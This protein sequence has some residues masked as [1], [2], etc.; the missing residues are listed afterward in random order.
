MVTKDED[1]YSLHNYHN[2]LAL[3]N[4]SYSGLAYILYLFDNMEN[5]I[6]KETL[7]ILRKRRM[8]LAN[9]VKRLSVSENK[10]KTLKQNEDTDQKKKFTLYF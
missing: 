5:L 2:V 7:K 3:I 1:P 4:W 8:H 9:K 10:I 6:Y